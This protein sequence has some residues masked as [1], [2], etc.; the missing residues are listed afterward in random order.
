MCNGTVESSYDEVDG[1]E[2][3]R[4][5]QQVLRQHQQHY[6]N[7]A[8]ASRLPPNYHQIR[9]APDALNHVDSGYRGTTDLPVFPDA[10]TTTYSIPQVEGPSGDVQPLNSIVNVPAA[11][12]QLFQPQPNSDVLANPLLPGQAYVPSS[13]AVFTTPGSFFYIFQHLIKLLNNCSVMCYC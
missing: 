8:A 12:R 6:T 7:Q 4:H 2:L 10:P 5:E 13:A 3:R 11:A 1:T 9:L